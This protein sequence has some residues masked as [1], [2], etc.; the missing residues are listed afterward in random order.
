[1]PMLTHPRPLYR[2]LHDDIYQ[3]AEELMYRDPVTHEIYTVHAGF[4]WDKGTVMKLVP[5]AIVPHS[6]EMT[7]P[8]ALHDKFYRDYSVSRRTADRLLR[9]FL[10]EEGLARW[11]A[12]AAWSVVRMNL[13][14]GLRWG[15]IK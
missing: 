7:Y 15:K 8:S 10:I 13:K 12:W 1:M 4:E 6:D 5:R 9:Q 3:M 14:A 11:R 2:H